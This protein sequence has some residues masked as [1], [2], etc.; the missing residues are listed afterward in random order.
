LGLVIETDGLRYHRSPA[1]QAVD[2]ERDQAHTA[3]GLTPLRF[4]HHQV[5]HRPPYVESIL[6][7]TA[8]RLRGVA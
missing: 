1:Q 7:R 3:A 5:R 6:R 2:R 4:T 8:R